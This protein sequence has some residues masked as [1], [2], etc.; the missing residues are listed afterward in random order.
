[1]LQ[2]IVKVDTPGG[3]QDCRINVLSIFGGIKEL[4][5]AEILS[6]FDMFYDI[7]DS[8]LKET[9]TGELYISAYYYLST[10]LKEKSVTLEEISKFVNI[11]PVVSTIKNKL[12]DHNFSGIVITSNDKNKLV[13]LVEYYKAK[14][15][16]DAFFRSILNSIIEDINT[17]SNRDSQQI[18]DF[19][20]N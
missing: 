14:K 4:D 16:S 1:M 6:S 2:G 19:L 11:L 8:N 7:R 20:N 5:K 15:S 3:P 18:K 10:K 12:D 17:L 13:D 9:T